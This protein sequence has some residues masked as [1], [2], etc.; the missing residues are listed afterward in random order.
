MI[1][2]PAGAGPAFRPVWVVAALLVA[3]GV[4]LTCSIRELSQTFDE[5]THLL[6]GYQYWR[7]RDFGANPEHPPLLK[8]A[9]AL[10]IDG[11]TLFSGY[12]EISPERAPLVGM[13]RGDDPLR[14]R[15]LAM[16]ELLEPAQLQELHDTGRKLLVGAA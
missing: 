8:L 15:V 12:R 13:I 4:Q 14:R 9:A 16:V 6:A 1:P 11:V 2:A 3:L 5:S 10:R 7:H